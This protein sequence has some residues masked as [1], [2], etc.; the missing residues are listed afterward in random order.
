[1]VTFVVI[2]VLD[3]IQVVIHSGQVEL[4]IT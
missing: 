2:S 3:S 1:M 4:A